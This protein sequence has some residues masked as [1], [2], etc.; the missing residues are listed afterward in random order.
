MQQQTTTQTLADAVWRGT[1]ARSLRWL[2]LAAIGV[3]FLTVCS[4]IQIPFWPVPLTM[5]TFGVLVLGMAY[6]WR[7]G[8]TTVAAFLA[9]GAMG[10]PVFAGNTPTSVGLAAFMGPTG[11]YLI[12]FFFAAVVCGWLAEQGWDKRIWSTA[13]A[14]L[15]GNVIIY[16]P[17]LLW[18]GN[19]VGWDKPVLEWGLMPFLAGDTLKLLL[20]AV[21]LPLSWHLLG[22][23]DDGQA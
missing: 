23:K 9:V 4:K 5:Q 8:G 21:T 7:L 2:I 19:V 16:I 13:L 1:D 11:G 18:L 14:M 15:I 20:A 6:G 22:R 17:G 12:G 10:M 3:V